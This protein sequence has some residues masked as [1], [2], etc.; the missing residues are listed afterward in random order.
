LIALSRLGVPV[1]YVCCAAVTVSLA[2]AC[3][4]QSGNFP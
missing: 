2:D 1:A 4:D 3:A